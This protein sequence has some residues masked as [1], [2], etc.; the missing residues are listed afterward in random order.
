MM[1]LMVDM[2][3][4]ITGTDRDSGMMKEEEVP[5]HVCGCHILITNGFLLSIY[6]L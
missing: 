5:H 1:W 2:V 3:E 6:L 4:K